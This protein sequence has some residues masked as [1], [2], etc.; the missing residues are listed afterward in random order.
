M[1]D[2]L[3]DEL[4][5][6]RSQWGR[7]TFVLRCVSPLLGLLG[8]VSTYDCRDAHCVV[9]VESMHKTPVHVAIEDQQGIVISWKY[10]AGCTNGWKMSS[11]RNGSLVSLC[12]LFSCMRVLS[13]LTADVSTCQTHCDTHATVY[14]RLTCIAKTSIKAQHMA[15]STDSCSSSTEAQP[16]RCDVQPTL[17]RSVEP[18]FTTKPRLTRSW[19]K[20][21]LQV[22]LKIYNSLLLLINRPF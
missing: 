5:L 14:Y 22:K 6:F 9:L 2:A 19:M 11:R 8:P 10:L 17:V 18:R 7:W 20:L 4:F 21:H 3:W 16:L 1:Q 15:T 13:A 12:M